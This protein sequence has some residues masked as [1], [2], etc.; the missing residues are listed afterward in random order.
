MKT[1][2]T[3]KKPRV[4]RQWPNFKLR[5]SDMEITKGKSETIQ[6]DSYT[7]KEILEKFSVG[8]IT[9]EMRQPNFQEG[10][11][12]ESIDLRQAGA[13]DLVD[14]MELLDSVRERQRVA[15]Q[16]LKQAEDDFIEDEKNRL[17][18][19][20]EDE[21]KADQIRRAREEVKGG[22]TEDKKPAK[23]QKFS[24]EDRD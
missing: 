11:S 14:R 2:N 5:V 8:E 23:S 17:E 1:E 7:I 21:E 18:Q 22:K 24:P 20:K 6:D 16:K 12:H 3:S 19:E 4:S 9:G 15:A 13:A 10:A